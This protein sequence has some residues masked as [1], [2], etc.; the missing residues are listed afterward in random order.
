MLSDAIMIAV[1]LA[2]Y[3]LGAID[4]D[5]AQFVVG[6]V[7]GAS[8]GSR[9]PARTGSGGPP[10]IGGVGSIVALLGSLASVVRK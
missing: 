4:K 10:D 9:I 5:M 7:L 6:A 2:G 1:V 3:R 8:F